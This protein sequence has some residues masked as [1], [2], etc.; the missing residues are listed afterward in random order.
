MIAMGKLFFRTH[1]ENPVDLES[2]TLDHSV[3]QPLLNWLFFYI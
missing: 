2:T 3:T 1:E